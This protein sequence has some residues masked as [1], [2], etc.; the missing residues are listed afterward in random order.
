[1]NSKPRTRADWPAAP[2]FASPAA[3]FA[4]RFALLT[5]LALFVYDYPHAKDSLL[6]ACLEFSNRLYAQAAG[7]LVTLFDAQASVRDN[8][9][10]G[11]FPVA[12]DRGCDAL[13][14]QAPL[15]A[16]ILAFPAP[17]RLRAGGAAL[18][19]ALIWVVNVLRIASLYFAGTVSA[20]FF[21][22]MHVDVWPVALVVLAAAAFALWS[23]FPCGSFSRRSR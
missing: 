17:W 14:V 5:G 18:G 8:V 16:A 23:A 13:E 12:V 20:A 10:L 4:L 3:G 11:R 7:T 6:R 21:E 2:L 1:M 22:T 19:V 15:A 9:I